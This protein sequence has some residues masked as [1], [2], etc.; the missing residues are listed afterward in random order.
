MSI[1]AKRY[2]ISM[3]PDIHG[4]AL[5]LVAKQNELLGGKIR[6]GGRGVITLSAFLTELIIGEAKRQGMYHPKPNEGNQ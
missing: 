5:D 6:D 3:R 1:G 2:Q 4:L